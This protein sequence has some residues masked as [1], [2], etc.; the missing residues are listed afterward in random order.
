M[1]NA[2]NYII[3]LYNTHE[4]DRTHR[5]S[6][7][8]RMNPLQTDTA[9]IEDILRGMVESHYH[10][11]L[12]IGKTVLI[13]GQ[14]SFRAF[15][16]RLEQNP[17]TTLYYIGDPLPPQ[18]A[19]ILAYTDLNTPSALPAPVDTIVSI[20]N[21]CQQTLSAWVSSLYPHLKPNGRILLSQP[22]KPFFATFT[23]VAAAMTSLTETFHYH[24]I[25]YHFFYL[26][27]PWLID[28]ASNPF[29]LE[30][31]LSWATT[32][33]AFSNFL[34]FIES[35]L[36]Q[37]LP[38]HLCSR[39]LLVLTP[40]AQTHT[41]D[42]PVTLTD[43]DTPITPEVLAKSITLPLDDWR[44]QLS[45]HLTYARNLV[46]FYQLI[47]AIPSKHDIDVSPYLTPEALQAVEQILIRQQ[48]QNVTEQVLHTWHEQGDIGQILTFDNIPL[49]TCFDHDLIQALLT[50]YGAFET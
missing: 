35:T 15:L 17:E 32:D 45:E 42:A 10:R 31:T 9:L 24:S 43:L 22:S 11:S 41:T 50:S 44:L 2:F 38:P 34:F 6:T 37:R 16:P 23:S 46:L 5:K 29:V 26:D 3:R 13:L 36:L 12:D 47:S 39:L 49:A 14:N 40:S 28:V 4:D 7:A 25:P 18:Y 20:E 1:L 30:K 21:T 48:M 19:N 33:V 8:T 27:N